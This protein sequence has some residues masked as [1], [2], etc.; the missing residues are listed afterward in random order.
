M[1]NS[2]WKHYSKQK[3]IPKTK[4]S[5]GTTI[6]SAN[7]PN[8]IWNYYSKR[9]KCPIQKCIKKHKFYNIFRKNTNKTQEI[10][11]FCA[12]R[13]ASRLASQAASRPASQPAVA[14]QPA[15]QP[16]SQPASQD[17]AQTLSR[18]PSQKQYDFFHKVITN[19]LLFGQIRPRSILA[20]RAQTALRD[21]CQSS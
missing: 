20:P 17:P 1:L 14:S 4:K 12:S 13:P 7:A 3:I 15:S 19:P 9:K 11:R 6:I 21:H 5:F 8:V 2:I 16:T 18:A 10:Q